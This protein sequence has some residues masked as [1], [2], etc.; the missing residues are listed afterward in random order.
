MFVTDGRFRMYNMRSNALPIATLRQLII[1]L[2]LNSS[3]DP[4]FQLKSYKIVLLFV[5]I[6]NFPRIISNSS[7][8]PWSIQLVPKLSPKSD[9]I[10]LSNRS[11]QL[12]PSDKKHFTLQ[13]RYQSLKS[14][15]H[16]N[17]VVLTTATKLPTEFVHVLEHLLLLRSN[18]IPSTTTT[19]PQHFELFPMHE[20][21][22]NH[23]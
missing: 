1:S 12:S 19:V 13:A 4:T 16:Q 15:T 23:Q 3:F 8:Y 21:H 5:M 11:Y 18:H 20:I 6:N 7:E 22:R 17:D 10:F 14:F 2:S 9:N